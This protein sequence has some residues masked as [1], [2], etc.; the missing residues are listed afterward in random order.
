MRQP[1]GYEEKGK[2]HLV[3]RLKRSIYGL[4]QS[5]CCWN[6]KLHGVL[7]KMGFKQSNADQ[8]LY[9]K[10]ENG[11]K[12]YLLV[13]VDDIM[14]GCE[15]EQYIDCVYQSLKKCFEITDLGDLSYFLG[16]EIK[17][18]S[19]DYSVSLEGYID[20]LID[21][22]G[23]SE[24]KVAKT[25]MDE[26][27]LKVDDTS[28]ALAD[29]TKYRSLVGGLLYIS[30]CARPDISVST[31][32]LGRKVSAPTEACWVAAKR[33]VRYL[34]ATKHWRLVY[35]GSG[36][37]LIGYA[38]ADWAGDASS[39]KSTTGYVFCY[40]NGAVS[41]A[42]RKQACVTLS[43]MESEYVALS[44]A[45]QEL[46]WLRRLMQDMGEREEGPTKVM[47]DNQSCI[48]FVNSERIN[49][50][51]KHIETKE[52]FVK[53]QCEQGLLKLEY[54]PTEHM[55]ADVLTKPLGTTKQRK[56][57]GMLGLSAN[58]GTIR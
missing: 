54:C 40:A 2:E 32:I 46:V 8:C 49:R 47:E 6:Q 50:R 51:S 24:A 21:K 15:N 30:V 53:Q 12:V 38:D 31:A 52:C 43:S 26:G 58:R 5:A 37:G 27:F 4:K 7:L 20:K 1:P 22:F 42:S 36:G 11:K 56:F 35:N 57:S 16:L 13:N 41:W 18:E 14:V 25:P 29:E 34:K 55:V 45:T 39:R 44:E 28:A 10:V 17:R 3:C 19:G 48:S 9:T 33:V 23:L